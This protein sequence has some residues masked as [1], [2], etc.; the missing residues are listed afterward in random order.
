MEGT[1]AGLDRQG[2]VRALQDMARLTELAGDEPFKARAFARGARVVER[3]DDATLRRLVEERRLTALSGIGRGLAAAIAELHQSGRSKTLDALRSR[4]PS[5]SL[6]LSR[7]PGLSARTIAALHA[8]LRIETVAQLEAACV[9]GRAR[10]VKGVG[11][12]TERRILDAIR[13]LQEPTDVRMH[14]HQAL[15]V[16]EPLLAH[17]RASPDAEWV[18]LAGDLR[19]WSETV[20]RLVVVAATTAP[21]AVVAHLATSSLVVSVRRQHAGAAAT[22]ASGLP[23]R[24]RLV[25]PDAWAAAL[26]H[27]TGAPEH[28]RDL[29]RVAVARDL[30]LSPSGLIERRTRRRLPTTDEADIY[31]ALGLPPVPP[32]L[33]EG[34]GE[35]AAAL[36]GA[37]P[38]DL[39]ALE[40]LR[41]VVHCHTVHSDGKHTI[42]EMARAAE[43][44]GLEYLTITD[45][46]QTASYAGGL[47]VDRLKA[48]W[49][50][51]ARVQESVG[52]RL[53][54][55]TESDI[56]ADGALD[57][58]DAVL[59]QLDVV[60]A[61]IHA[62]HRMDADRMTRRLVRAMRHPCFKVWGH[63]LGRLVMSRPP[64]ACRVEE[65]LDAAAASRAAIEINGDPHRL[66]LEPRW[67]R[68]AHDR[69]IPFVVSTDAHSTPELQNQRYGVAMARRGWVRR[70]EVLNT[71]DVAG[72][73]RA[74]SPAGRA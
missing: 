58:P 46:S 10:T 31:R 28:V 1:G 12:K 65:V 19:R 36:D 38:D 43:A 22:L 34:Q 24:L 2:V 53:L 11:E 33:R 55:G 56:L 74:V 64:I 67:V 47:D 69:G 30:T 20:D 5:G 16:A 62:R 68:A 57:Y 60:I 13:S 66:D 73:L 21:D 49:E 14:L 39:V 37:L 6:E 48:Q 71:R 70:G 44:L 4:L 17:L 61:S 54:R 18:E 8:A 40:D 23:L 3:L 25:P 32:E 63:A 42:A 15:A 51:I 52:V 27:E 41:G 26:V 35:V 9:E 29:A 72:F 50:E 59:E 45:H 7:V